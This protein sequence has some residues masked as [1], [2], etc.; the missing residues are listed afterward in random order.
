MDPLRKLV[1][2]LHEEMTGGTSQCISADEQPTSATWALE[3]LESSSSGERKA[4]F[5]PNPQERSLAEQST[6]AEPLDAVATT[7]LVQQ[8]EL[9]MH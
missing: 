4:P 2:V 9:G 8:E 7:V 6:A 1:V 5:N 3:Q